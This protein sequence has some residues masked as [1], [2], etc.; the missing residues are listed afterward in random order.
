MDARA[1]ITV[2]DVVGTIRAQRSLMLSL[3][4]FGFTAGM[5]RRDQAAKRIDPQSPTK[6]GILRLNPCSTKET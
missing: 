6:H 2:G 3:S 4:L 5:E 1:C